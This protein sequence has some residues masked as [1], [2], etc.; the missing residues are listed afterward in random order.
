MLINI[1]KLEII[2]IS[3]Q[4]NYPFY[5]TVLSSATSDAVRF[6]VYHNPEKPPYCLTSTN[7]RFLQTTGAFPV[8]GS[9]RYTN[10]SHD[11]K[12][13]LISIINYADLIENEPC[14]N[15]QVTEYVGVLHR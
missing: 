7:Q 13:S 4:T 1:V 12:I 10:V 2:R 5:K 11:P 9:Y 6:D 3:S 8:L 14:E 15:P